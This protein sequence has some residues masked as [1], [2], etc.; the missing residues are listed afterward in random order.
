MRYFHNLTNLE[1]SEVLMLKTFAQIIE[2]YEQPYW[3]GKHEALNGI[4]GCSK[5]LGITY[6]NTTKESC[7]NCNFLK[8]ESDR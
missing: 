6:E 8:D 1:K 7:K 3:C 5:L 2:N 4:F